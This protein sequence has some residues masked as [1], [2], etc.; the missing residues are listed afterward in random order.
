MVRVHSG[1]PSRRPTN[2]TL[3]V[4]LLEE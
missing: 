3:P 1:T 4:Q 2:V